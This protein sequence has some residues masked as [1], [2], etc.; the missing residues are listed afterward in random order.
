M[1]SGTNTKTASVLHWN[2]ENAR[3]PPVKLG[4]ASRSSSM[5]GAERRGLG[6]D[7]ESQELDIRVRIEAPLRIDGSS[8]SSPRGRRGGA[9]P[10]PGFEIGGIGP[11]FILS[12]PSCAIPLRPL[13]E[14]LPVH[15]TVLGEKFV[16]RTVHDGHLM[17]LSGF[18]ARLRSS[19]TPTLSR[20]PPLRSRRG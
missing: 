18:E 3:T 4:M 12:L 19:L 6:E 16:G 1:R 20:R 15:V 5:S 2:M 7:K 14:P 13:A 8:R 9:E 11:P 17:E 10:P